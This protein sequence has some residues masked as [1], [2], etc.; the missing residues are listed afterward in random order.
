MKKRAM[1]NYIDSVG[2]IK[3]VGPNTFFKAIFEVKS[4]VHGPP[5]RKVGP[6]CGPSKKQQDHCDQKNKQNKVRIVSTT[7]L[8]H[9]YMYHYD[10]LGY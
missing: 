3:V 6:A 10:Q 9:V 2:Q 5:F 8:I 7:I 1:Q 4:N